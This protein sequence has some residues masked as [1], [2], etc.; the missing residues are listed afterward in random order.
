MS[1]Y[2]IE[3]SQHLIGEI[4][5]EFD[6][7]FYLSRNRQELALFTSGYSNLV[8]FSIYF[9]PACASDPEMK[10]LLDRYGA[11]PCDEPSPKTESELGLLAGDLV[12]W[13]DFIW[14]PDI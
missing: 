3:N 8:T 2:K 6:K 4:T 1:W 7:I 9:S 5:K 11:K 13:K 12:R 14:S 10:S